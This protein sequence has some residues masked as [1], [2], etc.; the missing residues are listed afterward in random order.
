MKLSRRQTVQ[1]ETTHTQHQAMQAYLGRVA[2]G[3]LL[4]GDGST[5]HRRCAQKPSP[6]ASMEETA[7]EGE[8]RWPGPKFVCGPN[9]ES[10]PVTQSET[11]VG[12][13]LSLLLGHVLLQKKPPFY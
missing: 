6:I 9:R 13:N 11:C 4:A 5:R 7:S 10:G 3:G 2:S 12:L 8:K 1:G